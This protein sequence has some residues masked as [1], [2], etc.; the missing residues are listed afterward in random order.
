M[1][2]AH[3]NNKKKHFWKYTEGLYLS[4]SY[5]SMKKTKLSCYF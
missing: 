2:T 1:Y 3:N 5:I 4:I